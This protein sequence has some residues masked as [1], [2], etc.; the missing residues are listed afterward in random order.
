MAEDLQRG[1]PHG[2][3]RSRHA[4]ARNATRRMLRVLGIAALGCLAACL[5]GAL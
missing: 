1:T 2:G 4:Q 5:C 3:K